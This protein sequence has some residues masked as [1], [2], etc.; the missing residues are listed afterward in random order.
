MA[1]T[2]KPWC[3]FSCATEFR[4]EFKRDVVI[5]MFCYRRFGHNE[6]DEPSFTQPLMYELIAKQPSVRQDLRRQADPRENADE[7]GCWRDRGRYSREVAAGIR[8]GRSIQAE[9]GGLVARQ[10][11]GSKTLIG[12]EE[13]HDDRASVS[14]QMLRDIGRA[15]YI[16]PPGLPA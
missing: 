14:E 16:Y 11:G 10:V 15:L 1:M 8:G 3:T 4:Q 7:G 12:E 13:L 9:Y 5:D 6:A 2:R